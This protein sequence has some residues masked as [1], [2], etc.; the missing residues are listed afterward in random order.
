MMLVVVVVLVMVT[1]I[2]LFIINVLAQR[3]L[4]Q[5]QESAKETQKIHGTRIHKR[6]Y[7]QRDNKNK[8]FWRVFLR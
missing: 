5:L 4:G 6:K 1:I 7:V 8:S 3:P 2:Q